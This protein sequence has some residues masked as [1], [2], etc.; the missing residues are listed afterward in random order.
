MDW[1]GPISP[2]PF[3]LTGSLLSLLLILKG[4]ISWNDAGTVSSGKSILSPDRPRAERRPS[5]LP[6]WGEWGLYVPGHIERILYH[7]HTRRQ[8][9][10][11]IRIARF[12]PELASRSPT[13]NGTCASHSQ[14]QIFGHPDAS[15]F[16]QT[17]NILSIQWQKKGTKKMWGTTLQDVVITNQVFHRQSRWL[18]RSLQGLIT[19]TRTKCRSSVN[20]PMDTGACLVFFQTPERI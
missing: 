19:F 15:H 3:S 14:R 17:N 11:I 2:P 13:V 8:R 7:T 5:H 18:R 12:L 4:E 10:F 20:G 6:N 1:V 9:L 16:R